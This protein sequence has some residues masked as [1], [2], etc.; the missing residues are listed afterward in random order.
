MSK[1]LRRRVVVLLSVTIAVP[2][3]VIAADSPA[4]A[5]VGWVESTRGLPVAGALVSVMGSGLRSGGVRAIADDT[6][7]FVLP[8]LPAGLYTLRAVGLNH[9]PSVAQ[10]LTLLPNAPTALTLS[11]QPVAPEPGLAKK[12][13]EPVAPSEPELL[14]PPTETDSSPDR[15]GVAVVG[16]T[17][18]ALGARVHGL[19]PRGLNVRGYAGRRRPPREPA[20]PLPAGRNHRG[21][22]GSLGAASPTPGALG[23]A[24]AGSLALAGRL[25]ELGTWA[26]DGLLSESETSAWRMAA[27]FILEPVDDHVFEVGAG[28]GES[29]LQSEPVA[30]A[31]I[32]EIMDGRARRPERGSRQPPR[33]L[34]ASRRADCQRRCA[35]LVL[36]F[37]RGEESYRPF[38]VHRGPRPRTLSFGAFRGFAIHCTGRGPTDPVDSHG[39]THG[40]PRRACLTM[41]EPSRLYRYGVRFSAPWGRTTLVAHVLQEDVR[42]QILTSFEDSS[43]GG[44]TLQTRNGGAVF[45]RG[46][47]FTV[48]RRLGR[49]LAGAVTYTWG[50][51]WRPDPV[52]LR[53]TPAIR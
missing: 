53:P 46:V 28:Y 45:T 2:G 29:G 43:D 16:E 18:P 30:G 23:A 44:H 10:R 12:S 4:R 35:L 32:A 50:R 11:L 37:P 13:L 25:P 40:E 14:A 47:G 38:G 9:L 31:S 34:G 39:G 1:P 41:R 7:R 36:R 5:V 17:S 3:A 26:L 42:N 48:T 20:L 33:P 6:G 27:E 51:S 49:S 22:G 15:R 8:P 52:A 24:G 19:P 21:R